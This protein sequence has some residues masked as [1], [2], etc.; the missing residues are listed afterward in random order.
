MIDVLAYPDM[1]VRSFRYQYCTMCRTPLVRRLYGDDPIPQV[2]CPACGWIANMSNLAAAVSVVTTEGGIVTI[3]PE[4]LPPESPAALPAG[5]IEYGES[6]EEAAVREIR[7]ETGLEAQ[8][9]RCL[10]WTYYREFSSVNQGGPT[11]AWP[12]PLLYFM[13]EART[14]GGSP[15]GSSEGKVRVYP[16]EAFPDIVCPQRGGSWRAIQAYLGR[17]R[18]PAS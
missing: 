17:E 4:G 8:L 13:F 6:P 18:Q 3:L 10:G 16:L 9:V 5:L 14:T 7:E 11:P 2:I 1:V 15:K 12:G